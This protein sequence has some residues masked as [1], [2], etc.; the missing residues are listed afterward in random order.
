MNN[1]QYPIRPALF[2]FLALFSVTRSFAQPSNDNCSGAITLTSA[3][4]CTAATYNIRNATSTSSTAGACGGAT[5]ST[6]FDVWFTFQA[7]STTT[8]IKIDNLGQRLTASTTY[9]EVLSGAACAGF[10]SLACQNIASRLTVTGLTVGTFY[11]I[12]VYVLLSP[13]ANP[14]SKWNFDI[15]VQTQPTNDNCA[16]AVTLTPG[17]ACTN[18]AGTLDLA[19]SNTTGVVA[20]CWAANTYND[21]WYKFVATNATHT[22]TLSSMGANITNPRIQ[23]YSGTCA[24]LAIVGCATTSTLTQAG[25]TIGATYYVRIANTTNP[26]GTGGVANFN[27]CITNAAV[28]PANDLCAN[29]YT[30]TSNASCLSITGTLNNATASGA[31]TCGSIIATSGDVWYT[32]VAQSAYPTISVAENFPS[33]GNAGIEIYS[34]CGGS[35]LGTCAANTFNVATQYPT[36]LT[37]GNTY[38]VRVGSSKSIGSPAPATG[39]DF[40]ICI[41]DPSGASVDFGKSYINITKGTNGGTIDPGDVLEI[42]A[43]LVVSGSGKSIDSVAYYDTLLNTKGFALVPGSIALRT[44]EGK[45]YKS[46][47]DNYDSDNGWRLAYGSDTIIQ[48]NMGSGATNT[49]RGRISYNSKPSNFGSTCI[50]M[51]TY[52]VVVYAGYDTKINYGGGKFSYK[53][54][55]TGI[56][57]SISFERDSLI[58]FSSPGLCPNSLSPT[59]IISDEYSGTFG[60]ASGSSPA[61]NRGTSPNTNYIY[62][63]FGSGGPNDYYYGVANNTSGNTATTINT[64]AKPNGTYRVFSVWDITGDHTGATNTAKGNNPCDVTQPVSASNPCGY[65]LVVNSAYNTDTAFQYNV[66]GLCPN[67][68]YEISAWLKNVCYKCGCDSNGVGTGGAGYIPTGPG[69]SSGIKPNIAFDIDGVDYYTTGNLQYQGLGGTQTGSDSLNT[70]VQ[71][72]FT[73][74]TGASQTSFMLTL[75]NNAP[76]GGGNDWA[77]DDIALKTCSPDITV[78]PG[79]NPFVCDSNTVDIGAT[80][81]S[82]FDNYVYYTWEKSTDNGA[83]WTSTGISGGPATPT[84]NGSAWTYDVTYP[85]FV[86]YA[87]DSGSQ[88]RVVV[89]STSSNLSNSSCRFSNGSTITLTVDPCG[90]L[91]DVDILSFKGKNENNTATLYLTT[92]KEEEPVKYEIQKSKDG[93]RFV[94]IGE[95]IGFKDPS[96]ETNHYTYVDPEALDNT[97]SWYRIK[98]IKT[99]NNKFKYSKVI[100][101]I[102]DKAGLQ[103]ESLINPF[104][105]HVKFDLISGDD[106]LVQV[107]ILDQ[108]QHKLKI[109]SYNLMKGKNKIDIANTDKLPAGFY[110]LRVISGN[111]IVNR[112]IIK[113]A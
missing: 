93:S 2:F 18:T 6:T 51:A 76:G 85:T 50:V 42:R 45:I 43:T 104:S 109:G 94:T 32:F 39:Y 62:A 100:Q 74:K 8:T 60:A 56:S 15:C 77:I 53:D 35:P 66:T 34:V 27:I 24:A 46:Y 17:A 107:E 16:G 57:G 78:T 105:S 113:K 111:H 1:F 103:I 102:G 82:Y 106:G 110:I 88:Y 63:A 69:D 58:V 92:S 3:N 67:T 79:P 22:V 70:W 86:A 48:I 65:M 99:Q 36:G 83:T 90:A 89:A 23:I 11:Y 80:I 59:N 71:R 47:T 5:A 7:T 87:A 97:L 10:S 108:Y 64:W 40:T 96:A 72:G 73:Y 54:A 25:L 12:R 14:A 29:A 4:T 44:N 28:A 98:A 91:L 68:Y 9:V 95:I 37:V 33:G 61:R 21:V 20:N 84:W 31:S 55:S 112:K 38:W 52:Q 30:I 75:R 19:T 13:T 41:T 49:A 101:M 26:S 81:S